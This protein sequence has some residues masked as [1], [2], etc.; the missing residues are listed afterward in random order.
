MWSPLAT[1]HQ[2]GLV[3]QATPSA[4]WSN[5]FCGDDE[6][7]VL[8][9]ATESDCPIQAAKAAGVTEVVI[10]QAAAGATCHTRDGDHHA[11]ALPV[12]LV[13]TVGAGDAFA[14]GYLSAV[15][16]DLPVPER[17]TRATHFAAFSIS[18]PGDWEGLPH[19][20]DLDLITTPQGTT[21]R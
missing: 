8:Q 11:P 10:K 13:D 7:Q 5:T 4:L 12:P 14:A 18:T 16:D 1:M 9:A 15:M 3:R 2:L 21:V 19:H 17:L 6:L 20:R